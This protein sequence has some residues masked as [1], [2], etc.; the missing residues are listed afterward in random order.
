MNLRPR[1]KINLGW[2]TDLKL[3]SDWHDPRKRKL[4]QWPSSKSEASKEQHRPGLCE[5]THIQNI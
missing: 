1:T 5:K 4:I 3:A 2:I